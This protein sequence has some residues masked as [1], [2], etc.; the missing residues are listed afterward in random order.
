MKLSSRTEIDDF[1]FE[2]TVFAIPVEH[3]FRQM[4]QVEVTGP[5]QSH[6]GE[7]YW[8][9]R[10][11]DFYHQKDTETFPTEQ[12][13]RNYASRVKL[14]ACTFR[15]QHCGLTIAEFHKLDREWHREFGIKC[16]VTELLK[17]DERFG[18]EGWE[19]DMPTH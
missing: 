8:H 3:P 9:V 6:S 19:P 2:V 7:V 13:A 12:A 11:R 14:W 17:Q 10:S 15:P 4:Q 1:G 18:R 16:D 5:H